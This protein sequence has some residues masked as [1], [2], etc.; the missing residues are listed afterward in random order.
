LA[1]LEESVK[2]R[3]ESSGHWWFAVAVV[4]LVLA[5]LYYWYQIR[6][7]A[8]DPAPVAAVLPPPPAQTVPPVLPSLPSAPEYPLQPE[9]EA[10]PDP[11]PVAPTAAAGSAAY[12]KQL[13]A[14]LLG[15]SPLL[16]S[17]QLDDFARRVVA[18]VDNLP[19]RHVAPMLW[20]LERS[21][22]QLVLTEE[23]GRKLLTSE[24]A[25]RYRPLVQALQAVDTAQAVQLYRRIYPLL[26]SAYEELGYPGRYFND[27]LVQVID[28]LLATPDLPDP[29]A[30]QLP[31]V[32]P[33]A[34]TQATEPQPPPLQPWVRY[35][36]ADSQLEKLS[37][38]QKIMLRVGARNRAD[39]KAKLREIRAA[40][41]AFARGN[42]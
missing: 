31:A 10:A 25:Q 36:F 18:T 34:E 27:R 3:Q 32:N 8:R 26:Q 22:G 1:A 11:A 24:N 28:H 2:R 14:A 38:G 39:L 40:I 23:Q 41:T 13:L 5:G 30:V 6:P 4:L 35:E 15:P 29:I 33:A 16:D 9:S 37:A 21:P 42:N 12:F 7:A 20:P 19:S 17:L